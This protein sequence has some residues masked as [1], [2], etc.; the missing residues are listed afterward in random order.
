MQAALKKLFR[1]VLP[2]PLFD[3]AK[4]LQRRV[5]FSRQTGFS[6][7]EPLIARH[8]EALPLKNR[9]AVDIAAQDGIG[10]SQTL[11]LYKRDWQGIAV[12]YDPEMFVILSAFYRAF[13]DVSLVRGK[14]TPDNV[15]DM[16]RGCGCPREFA[17]LS[18]D[19]DSYDHFVLERILDAYRPSLMCVEINEIIP[20][21]L[22]F[23]VKYD[24]D[25]RWEGNH[26]QGQSIAQCHALCDV[27]QYDIL[28][29]HYNNL[30]L[31]PRELHRSR[32]LSPMEAYDEGYRN[33]TD[34]KTKFPWNADVEPVHQ[35]SRDDAMAF[36]NGKFARYAG[37][38]VLE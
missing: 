17:F 16:L 30:L 24:P 21:P 1:A 23:T 4:M 32:A 2:R 28:E 9:F 8:L 18:L 26:F 35:M 34:R 20:P 5:H 31:A 38:Y 6:D 13:P 12:E 14:V 11:A 19:I 3:R 36:L 10:G 37:K 27:H 22:R 33:R 29:L 7:E 15:V 25:F